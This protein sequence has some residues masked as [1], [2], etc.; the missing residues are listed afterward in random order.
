MFQ[1]PRSDGVFSTLSSFLFPI[2][3]TMPNSS[4]DDYHVPEPFPGTRI[5][6]HWLRSQS[7][8]SKST[9][10]TFFLHSDPG[11]SDRPD[12]LRFLLTKQTDLP[13]CS[14]TFHPKLTLLSTQVQDRQATQASQI[15][16]GHPSHSGFRPT[17]SAGV[18]PAAR[19][20][21]WPPQGPSTEPS[22]SA[23]PMVCGLE[24]SGELVTTRRWLW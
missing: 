7:S 6:A 16:Y 15:T 17:H 8:S 4:I 2:S 10:G 12:G 24:W 18:Q 23:P 19:Q 9:P 21:R 20:S 1:L 11:G 22:K 3:S 13:P 14:H 5:G